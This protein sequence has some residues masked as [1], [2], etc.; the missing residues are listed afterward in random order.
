MDSDGVQTHV[1]FGPVVSIIADD[2]ALRDAC[3]RAYN[4]W[5]A[6]F[7]A[8]APDRLIGVAML[9]ESPQAALQEL[10]RLATLGGCRQANLQ[11]ANARPR[12]HDRAWEPFWRRARGERA[13]SFIPCDRVFRRSK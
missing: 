12:L 13:D 4:D 10:L 5:L 2:P 11:I 7:C 6:E 9:P 8:A 1:M 3:Y